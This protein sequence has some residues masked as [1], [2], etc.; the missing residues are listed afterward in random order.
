[1]NLFGSGFLYGI[2]LTDSAGNAIATNVAVPQLF[3]TLQDVSLDFGF[4]NKMLYGQLQFPVAVGRGKGKISC[5]AKFAN[6]YG[7]MYSS[8]FFGSTV[9]ANIIAAVN[10][11]TGIV[12]PTTPFTITASTAAPS[13]TSI[14]IPNSGVWSR[15][16]GVRNGI[17]GIPMIRVASAPTTG[18]YTV[19]A[20]VYVFAAADVAILMFI[21]YEYTAAST[22]A[23]Q[24]TVINT[25]MGYAPTFM[26]VLS[27]PFQGKNFH[28][29]L[30]VCIS[31]K[32]GL[33]FKND[34]FVI[35]ELDFDAF[36]DASGNVATFATTE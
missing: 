29:R 33:G 11:V 27:A 2:P 1:M 16:L 34:D 35:P 6:I 22:S 25:A 24:F 30:P 36:A 10:D 9:A 19:A 21:S 4:E 8:L 5:K 3:G 23:K 20:G 28:C 31:S 13:A 17:T 15:D 7:Q 18:Q 12:V 14:Q 32:L 26:A